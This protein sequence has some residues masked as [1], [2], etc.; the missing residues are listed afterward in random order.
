MFILLFTGVAFLIFTIWLAR[1]RLRMV[2]VRQALVVYSRVTE[3]VQRVII[4]PKKSL[5]GPLQQTLLLDL[6][7][8]MV[9]LQVDNL[10]TADLSLTASLDI[11]CGF[12]PDLLQA[13]NLNQTFPFLSKA[14]QVTQSW[15][16]HILRKLAAHY[17]TAELL[18]LPTHRTRFESALRHTLQ[19]R[20]NLLGVRIYTLR[21][22][23]QP[24]PELLEAQLTVAQAQLAMEA[25]TQAL[26][27]LISVLGSDH[28]A[29]ILL[30]ELLQHVKPD[31]LLA[32]FNLSL[33]IIYKA[34]RPASN[35][36]TG[37]RPFT[38]L[39]KN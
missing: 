9:H 16:N 13:A 32:G 11:F 4:G 3:S 23:Y 33:P 25:R 30:L 19:D 17:T 35:M 20:L 1:W 10:T 34:D 6:T 18:T 36:I 29:Q 27:K 24:A 38:G 28:T 8:Q 5:I 14:E 12:D 37:Y 22:L 7:T 39:H 26:T 31:H 2:R 15:A 21:L